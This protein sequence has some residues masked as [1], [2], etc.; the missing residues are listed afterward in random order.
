[1]LN[2][3]NY[4]QKLIFYSLFGVSDLSFLAAVVS[5]FSGCHRIIFKPFSLIY[6]FLW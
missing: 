2:I 1:M 5:D 6:I 4:N 3:L